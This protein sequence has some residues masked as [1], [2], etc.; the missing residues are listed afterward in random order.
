[1]KK[2]AHQPVE[3]RSLAVALEM[4]PPWEVGSLKP[5]KQLTSYLHP[6]RA[7]LSQAAKT[8]SLYLRLPPL[9]MSDPAQYRSASDTITHLPVHTSRPR[10]PPPKFCRP[11]REISS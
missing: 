1:M 7:V 3:R 10:G 6:H 2:L 9:P 11:Y 5:R 4:S 8:T